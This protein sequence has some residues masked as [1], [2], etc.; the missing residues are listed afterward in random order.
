MSE[1][2]LLGTIA[3]IGDKVSST[4]DSHWH[5][6]TEAP[7]WAVRSPEGNTIT[8]AAAGATAFLLAA[9]GFWLAWHATDKLTGSRAALAV[10][11]GPWA[12]VAALLAG[13]C[14]A[15]YVA[16]GTGRLHLRMTQLAGD[17]TAAEA[18]AA[19]ASEQAGPDGTG[20]AAGNV[21]IA[22]AHDPIRAGPLPSSAR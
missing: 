19:S 7:R 3:K 20:A 22:A 14:V 6:T 21:R 1:P 5:F 12:A 17:E 4:D 2:T 18:L 9:S 10:Q 8:S 16:M 15:A 13:A 11:I